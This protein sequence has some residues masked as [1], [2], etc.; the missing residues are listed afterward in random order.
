[1]GLTRVVEKE[2]RREVGFA[3][4]RNRE[5]R[6]TGPIFGVEERGGGG[7]GWSWMLGWIDTLDLMKNAEV[8][9]GGGL[10]QID[11]SCLECA[12]GVWRGFGCDGWVLSSGDYV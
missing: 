12:V 3:R 5:W 7:S 11:T 10:G 1:M 6:I 9:N 2:R 4:G 8:R